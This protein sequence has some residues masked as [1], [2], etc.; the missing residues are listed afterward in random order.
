MRHIRLNAIVLW[1]AYDKEKLI[2][3]KKGQGNT[4][5]KRSVAMAERIKDPVCGMEIEKDA[6]IGPVEHRGKYFVFAG[7][8]I[9]RNLKK[10][11]PTF[12]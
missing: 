7:R 11:R 4:S 1:K 9:K 2:L 3:S 6:A 12:P 5:P 8:N 10:S